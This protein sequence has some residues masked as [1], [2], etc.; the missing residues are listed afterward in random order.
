M[1]KAMMIILNAILLTYLTENCDG[2]SI[3]FIH[4]R[5]DIQCDVF[6]PIPLGVHRHARTEENVRLDML[7]GSSAIFHFVDS[8]ID[9]CYYGMC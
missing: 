7:N 8:D 4:H 2:K 1:A 6:A 5:S 3:D 9:S